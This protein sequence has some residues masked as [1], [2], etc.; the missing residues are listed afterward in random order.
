M[1]VRQTNLR[2]LALSKFQLAK[3]LSIASLVGLI[4]NEQTRQ[5]S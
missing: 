5:D 2:L 3:F 1:R 4:F